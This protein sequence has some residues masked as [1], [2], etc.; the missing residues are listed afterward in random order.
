MKVTQECLEAAIAAC[1]VGRRMRD[2]SQAIQSVAEAAGYSPVQQ[3]TGHGVG[4]YVHEAPDVPNYVAGGSSPRLK[5]GMTLAIEPMINFGHYEVVSNDDGW[6]VATADGK[7]S[8]H[9]EHTVAV[10]ESGPAVLTRAPG[11]EE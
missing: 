7:L 6:T 4:K 11:A 8:A 2:V 3:L 9:Y 1:H 5:A 10:T